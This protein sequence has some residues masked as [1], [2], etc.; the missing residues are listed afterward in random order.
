V[1]VDVVVEDVEVIVVGEAD[2]GK[3]VVAGVELVAITIVAISI[4]VDEPS[5]YAKIDQEIKKSRK[6]KSRK[7][8]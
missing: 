4:A 2:V 3:D 6:T 8:K 5:P 7:E 1:V